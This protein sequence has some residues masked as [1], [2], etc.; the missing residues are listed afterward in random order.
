MF[1]GEP[2]NL[3]Q[4]FILKSIELDLIFCHCTQEKWGK[5]W[6]AEVPLE[7]RNA[8][9]QLNQAQDCAPVKASFQL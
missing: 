2:K 9:V 5:L 7:S 8:R 6:L 3:F 1:F 4:A